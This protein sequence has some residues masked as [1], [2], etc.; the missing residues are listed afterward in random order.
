VLFNEE[1]YPDDN[2][3][4]S[5]NR[6]FRAMADERLFRRRVFAILAKTTATV[7]WLMGGAVLALS[8]DFIGAMQWLK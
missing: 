7:L 6:A 5:E 8:G 3:S 1:N 4:P 2:L